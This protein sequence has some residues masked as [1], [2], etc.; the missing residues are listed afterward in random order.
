MADLV[1][2]GGGEMATTPAG[3][4]GFAQAKALS[5]R[6]DAPKEASRPWDRDRDGFVLG[7]GGGAIILEE[8]EQC[9]PVAGANILPARADWFSG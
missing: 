7:D 4:G 1:I 2:A 9:A 8:L 5:G 6:N 3:L